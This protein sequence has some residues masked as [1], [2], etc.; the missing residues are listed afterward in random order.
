MWS[1]REHHAHHR[2]DPVGPHPANQ[3]WLAEAIES[4]RAQQPLPEEILIIDDGANLGMVSG[5][6]GSCKQIWIPWP[7]GSA[8][9][10]NYC[11]GGA[12]NEL[13]LFLGSDDKLLPGCLEACWRAWERIHD[14]IG[15]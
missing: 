4:V 7:S 14:P 11:I 5:P 10:F 15:L 6:W 8:A 2:R 9:A 3:C 13:V 12:A 1:S